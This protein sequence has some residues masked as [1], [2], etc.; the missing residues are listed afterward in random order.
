MAHH[1]PR[2]K[3]VRLQREDLFSASLA[4]SMDNVFV[5]PGTNVRFGFDSIIGLFPGIGD[6]IGALIS[7][8]LIAHAAKVGV[9]KIILARMAGNVVINSFVGAIPF[10]GA[11]LSVFYRSNVKNY[12]LLRLHAGNR[13][14]STGRDWAFVVILLLAMFAIL[15]AF[16]VGLSILIGQ[17]AT[18][19]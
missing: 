3:A 8:V 7:S 2:A 16:I 14:T 4:R 5:I 19:P 9:P 10:L 18:T 6:A 13:G 11:V 17:I 1:E 12:E 15:A